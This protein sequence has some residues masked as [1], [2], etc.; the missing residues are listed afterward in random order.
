M[1]DTMLVSL[2]ASRISSATMAHNGGR[3]RCHYLAFGL[4]MGRTL[5]GEAARRFCRG[6][7][8]SSA[9]VLVGS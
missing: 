5:T 2:R 9:A 8:P 1:S 7:G 4:A 6:R 3:F